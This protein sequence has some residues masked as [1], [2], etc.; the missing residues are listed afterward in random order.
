[1]GSSAPYIG[2]KAIYSNKSYFYEISEIEAAVDCSSH[3]PVPQT[4]V[5]GRPSVENSRL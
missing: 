4:A 3:N 5:L 2:S 1:M